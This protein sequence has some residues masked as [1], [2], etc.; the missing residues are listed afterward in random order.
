M[1]G[2]RRLTE[3]QRGQLYVP[4]TKQ[5]QQESFFGEERQML[6][7]A[8]EGIAEH[9]GE[10][11]ALYLLQHWGGVALYIPVP[12]AVVKAYRDQHLMEEFREG[13]SVE[14][15]ADRYDVTTERVMQLLR[16]GGEQAEMWEE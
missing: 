5:A 16:S 6:P 9:V 10:D 1:D 11:V 14:E 12:D 3:Y 8:L 13:R 7:P 2:T 4:S 15:L